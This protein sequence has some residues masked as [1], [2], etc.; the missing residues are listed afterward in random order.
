MLK[1]FF[2]RNKIMSLGQNLWWG[3]KGQEHNKYILYPKH[4]DVASYNKMCLLTFE[5]G[6]NILI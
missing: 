2:R 1:A 3:Q 4:C 6:K 5:D